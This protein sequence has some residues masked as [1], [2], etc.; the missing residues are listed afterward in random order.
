MEVGEAAEVVGSNPGPAV[1][2]AAG[3]EAKHGPGKQYVCIKDEL[4]F[5]VMLT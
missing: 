2:A 4:D 5:T 1:A 3:M